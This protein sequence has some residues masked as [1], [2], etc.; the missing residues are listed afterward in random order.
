MKKMIYEC[1]YTYKTPP[2]H[3][4]AHNYNCCRILRVKFARDPSQLTALRRGISPEADG[5]EAK[6]SINDLT[7]LILNTLGLR[8]AALLSACS[9][10]EGVAFERTSFDTYVY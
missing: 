5:P 4:F 1:K 8:K 9:A 3:S 7:M 6:A 10:P 2:D